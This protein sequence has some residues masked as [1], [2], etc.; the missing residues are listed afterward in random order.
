MDIN[1]QLTVYQC[2]DKCRA[3]NTTMLAANHDSYRKQMAF[4]S[5]CA[6]VRECSAGPQP[7]TSS[8][9]IKEDLKTDDIH[10]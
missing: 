9:H 1:T 6:N 4:I 3:A 5:V 7:V 2:A 8:P 10:V